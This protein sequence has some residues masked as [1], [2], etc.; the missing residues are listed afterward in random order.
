VSSESG[1]GDCQ[2][3]VV[4]LARVDE[5]FLVGLSEFQAQRGRLDELRPGADDGYET[6]GVRGQRA[7]VRPSR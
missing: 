6:H 4:V 7:E 2:I 3:V 1:E 5:K